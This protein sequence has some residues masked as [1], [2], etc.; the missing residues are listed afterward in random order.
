MKNYI[1]KSISC[2]ARLV[3]YGYSKRSGHT[4]SKDIEQE[5]LRIIENKIMSSPRYVKLGLVTIS[6]LIS[7]LTINNGRKLD[8]FLKTNRSLVLYS[9][10]RRSRLGILRDLLKFYETFLMLTIYGDKNV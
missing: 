3:M 8:F 10:L 5:Y 9:T 4:I 2:L 7:P 6:I 1:H